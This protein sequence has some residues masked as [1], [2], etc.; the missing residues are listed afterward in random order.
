MN[1]NKVNSVYK[2]FGL[3]LILLTS[4]TLCGVE[5]LT[6]D[7]QF[8]E[9]R[10]KEIKLAEECEKRLQ[11]QRYEQDKKEIA[12]IKKR[13]AGFPEKHAQ[14]QAEM[15]G[16]LRTLAVSYWMKNAFLVGASGMA[17]YQFIYKLLWKKTQIMRSRYVFPFYCSICTID[18]LLKKKMDNDAFALYEAGRLLKEVEQRQDK[19]KLSLLAIFK[20][21]QEA[22]DKK[23]VIIKQERDDLKC[24]I[25]DERFKQETILKNREEQFKRLGSLT[26]E[27]DK[28][29]EEKARVDQE[30]HRRNVDRIDP[31]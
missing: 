15:N 5:N 30:I 3:L 11:E 19:D 27:R 28:L 24:K 4:V 26:Y 22:I 7:A 14:I 23:V 16:S 10:L 1:K 8:E 9:N 29:V 12:S 17:F 6:P 20:E 18:T 21:R 13:I 25:A 31:W 2:K